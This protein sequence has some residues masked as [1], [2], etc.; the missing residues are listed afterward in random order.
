M[1]MLLFEPI[2]QL[3]LVWDDWE[4]RRQSPIYVLYRPF[5]RSYII[6]DGIFGAIAYMKHNVCNVHLLG[7][8]DFVAACSLMSIVCNGIRLALR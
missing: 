6:E 4:I 3:T 7:M 8:A 1:C 5:V 2:S